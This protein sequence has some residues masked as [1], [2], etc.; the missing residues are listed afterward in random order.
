MMNKSLATILYNEQSS[1]IAPIFKKY[2]KSP[3]LIAKNFSIVFFSYIKNK[4]LHII[5]KCTNEKYYIISKYKDYNEPYILNK[6]Y[7][8]AAE[9]I[10]KEIEP[11]LFTYYISNKGI[12]HVY[13]EENLSLGLIDYFDTDYRLRILDKFDFIVG[14][15]SF[16]AFYN[17]IMKRNIS[18]I[19]SASF[20][21]NKNLE[22][23]IKD[24]KYIKKC[25]EKELKR[26]NEQI[27]TR[28]ELLKLYNKNLQLL[29]SNEEIDAQFNE[30][31]LKKELRSL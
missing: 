9:E 16:E 6:N 17:Y 5:L 27:S 12:N 10:I 31:N 25:E 15:S 22:Q 13:I 2:F 4:C 1:N 11:Q 19:L 7:C 23:A 28:E 29:K 14:C 3:E 30:Y 24:L 26:I 20:M 8:K 18:L 21:K